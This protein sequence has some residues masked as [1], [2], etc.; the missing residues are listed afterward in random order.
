MNPHTQKARDI[1]EVIEIC[2]SWSDRR[3]Q[4]KYQIDGMVIKVN[5]YDQ[6]DILG[7]TGRSPRW[8]IAYKYPAERAQTV[9]ESIAVQVGKTGAMTPVANLKAV[10]LAGTTVRRASLH[11]FDQMR[12]LD[13]RPGDTV[14]IEKAGE[15][16]PQVVEV[17][18]DSGRPVPS[19]FL[20]RGNARSA[21]RRSSGTRPACTFA[22]RI[23]RAP[24]S[25]RAAAVLRGPRPDGH[26]DL[27]AALVEQLS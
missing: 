22:V 20:C 12:R 4:L 26:R 23:P 13:V 5:R 17:K 19:R 15:I 16:I 3:S 7:A 10:Q 2:Q 14:L 6:R 24:A 27:G 8:C 1:A 25:S 11:N 21:A 18:T 9:V